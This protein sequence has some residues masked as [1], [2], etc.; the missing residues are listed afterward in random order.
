MSFSLYHLHI[1]ILNIS[2][3]YKKNRPYNNILSIY[4]THVAYFFLIQVKPCELR[5]TRISSPESRFGRLGVCQ[6]N[7]ILVYQKNNETVFIEKDV[8]TICLE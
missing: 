8:D 6:I 2:H 7:Q 3:I 4:T 5:R 1:T